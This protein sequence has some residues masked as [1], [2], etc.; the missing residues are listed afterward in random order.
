MRARSD[1]EQDSPRPKELEKII[2]DL[3]RRKKGASEAERAM[4]DRVLNGLRYRY[5][6]AGGIW[7]SHDPFGWESNPP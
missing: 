7:E 3:V 4:L 2:I 6:E 1:L 5:E